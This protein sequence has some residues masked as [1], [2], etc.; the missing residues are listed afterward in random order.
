[1]NLDK[2]L[3]APVRLKIVHDGK[4]SKGYSFTTDSIAKASSTLANI[5]ILAS[6]SES[7]KDAEGHELGFGRDVNGELI[8]KFYEA[9]IGVIPESAE[10]SLEFDAVHN[11]VYA[12]TTG[13]IWKKYA[14]EMY[15]VLERDKNKSISMEVVINDVFE[16]EDT[17][18]V[19]DYKYTG[20]T[21]LG[22][23]HT[24]GVEGASIELLE[25]L[26]ANFE[27]EKKDMNKN[28]IKGTVM[29]EE[30]DPIVDE[31]VEGAGVIESLKDDSKA[32]E[33]EKDVN[34][35]AEDKEPLETD[36]EP[37]KADEEEKPE[38]QM[39][40]ADL[41]ALKAA[42]IEELRLE[43][44]GESK[45]A[46][47]KDEPQIEEDPVEEPEEEEEKNGENLA[48]IGNL[49]K[50]IES[51]QGTISKYESILEQQDK[52]RKSTLLDKFSDVKETKEYSELMN[53]DLTYEELEIRLYA[54][55]G[56]HAAM[57]RSGQ[58]IPNVG[59]VGALAKSRKDAERTVDEAVQAI[60]AKNNNI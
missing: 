3:F 29:F 57:P 6:Y 11:K 31:N 53:E 50:Q 8:M 45:I 44:L 19:N 20:I 37:E 48:L 34:V 16:H 18:I 27:K 13:Y 51:L 56:M 33:E 41:E 1:M 15:S 35:P 30:S 26:G 52:E 40:K 23:T 58:A 47:A 12:T 2:S 49:Q 17:L 7:A 60:V 38:E 32:V 42:I 28:K 21:I 10:Y 24:P 25:E 43:A 5:P 39:A 4:T 59:G 9:P 55:R 22:A 54:I 14:N 36:T 46:E